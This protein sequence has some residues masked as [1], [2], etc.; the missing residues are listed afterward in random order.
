LLRRAEGWVMTSQR[1]GRFG[2]GLADVQIRL[3]R[4]QQGEA[5]ELLREAERAGWRGPYWRYHRDFD[6]VMAPIRNHAGFKAVFAD[7]ERDMARQRPAP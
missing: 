6:P 5:L 1:L 4:G 3:L 2:Y 7:I